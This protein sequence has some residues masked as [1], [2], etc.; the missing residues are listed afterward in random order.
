[1]ENAPRAPRPQ[2]GVP[3]CTA[4]PSRRTD[5]VRFSVDVVD[6]EELQDQAA[7]DVVGE[8]SVCHMATCQSLTSNFAATGWAEGEGPSACRVPLGG[9]LGKLGRALLLGLHAEGNCVKPC[10]VSVSKLPRDRGRHGGI[11]RFRA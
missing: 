2:N 6:A 11:G 10:R 7:E 8:R 3:L 1:M 9:D 4:P 5:A